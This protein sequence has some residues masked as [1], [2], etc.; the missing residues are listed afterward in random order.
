VVDPIDLKTLAQFSLMGDPSLQPVTVPH[1]FNVI[2]KGRAPAADVAEARRGLRRGR[3]ARVG[4]AV[5]EL[6]TTS[7][8]DSR[9]ATPGAV[10][11]L[12]QGEVERALR[13]IEQPGDVRAPARFSTFDV[14]R[15]T[16]PRAVRD[17]VARGPK[18]A[19]VHLAIVDLA[20]AASRGKE[21]AAPGPRLLA[22]VAVEQDGVLVTRR[23]L[24]R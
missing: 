2:S 19:A 8:S 23:L 15:P 18:A 11:K 9:R 4:A 7:A 6:A 12:L 20:G 17:L 1:A 5:G 24:S 10:R 13:E 14:N 3:L 16:P 21:S 22:V